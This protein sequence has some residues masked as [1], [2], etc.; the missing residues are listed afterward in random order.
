MP[1][2]LSSPLVGVFSVL[3]VARFFF[4]GIGGADSHRLCIIGKL[5]LMSGIG[6]QL[7]ILF[8]KWFSILCISSMA[9]DP[10]LIASSLASIRNWLEII[11]EFNGGGGSNAAI[12]SWWN[13]FIELN[14]LSSSAEL[15]A[16]DFT[17]S[18][19]MASA[20][21]SRFKL[22]RAFPVLILRC[23]LL[24]L[25]SVPL[26]T[27]A[28]SSVSCRLDDEFECTE[29]SLV[30]ML[31]HEM[32]LSRDFNFRC[33]D[34]G[35]NDRGSVPDDDFR[36][37]NEF[38]WNDCSVFG[39]LRMGS[40]KFNRFCVVRYRR[41]ASWANFSASSS[42]EPFCGVFFGERRLQKVERF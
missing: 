10:L 16:T 3:N 37:D 8:S 20:S 25:H 28:S 7:K 33:S 14:P 35:A 30:L 19:P 27:C 18:L 2:F 17:R 31:W 11:V 26:A 13:E 5:A 42:A 38:R 24:P 36:S 12:F 32:R 40:F 6:P 29:P 15:L 9:V 1:D 34:A 4:G 41:N 39:S 23:W 21:I 22:K